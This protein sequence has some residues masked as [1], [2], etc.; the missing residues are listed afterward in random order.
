[1][2]ILNINNPSRINGDTACFTRVT[3]SIGGP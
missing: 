3:L 1:M 2:E